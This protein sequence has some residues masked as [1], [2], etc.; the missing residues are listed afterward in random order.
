FNYF[1]F[2]YLP[3]YNKLRSVTFAL[4]IMLF[5]MPLLGLLGLEKLLREGW[6][7]VNQNK[8]IWVS[9]LTVGMCLLI[10]LTG[11][12]A[13]FL[14][15]GEE[16][17][18]AWF[19]SALQKDRMELLKSDAWR[20]F[21]FMLIFAA[22]LYAFLKKWIKEWIL[23]GSLIVLM[24]FDLPMVDRRFISQ[25]KFERKRNTTFE[26]W[27]SEKELSKDKTPFR[28]YSERGEG[29]HSY[30]FRATGGYSG[31]RLHR[32][33][34]LMDSCLGPELQAM[35]G[36]Y[37]STGRLFLP[38]HGVMSMM[39]VKYY[40]NGQKRTDFFT[41]DF[42]NGAAWF[43]KDVQSVNSANEELS[44]LQSINTLET[45]VV[46]VTKFKVAA[47]AYE[48]DSLAY[49]Q[50]LELKPPYIKYESQ[51]AYDGLAVFS[52]I[53]YPK[54]WH[55]KIDGK[56][57]PILRADYVLRALEVPAGKHSIEFSFEPKPYMIGNKITMA[58]SW[59]LVIIVA[60]SLGWSLGL[61]KK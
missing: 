38:Q 60:A 15:P 5:A 1:I 44:K 39:N 10:A 58:S 12:F 43:I 53:Y 61:E 47:T 55:A 17:F 35:V 4:V 57:V 56:E 29:N 3:G 28:I 2:D 31:A 36:Q 32:Y 18:P 24:L 37:N 54:G 23:L 13:D 51:S 16:R 11:G 46:D 8:L 50:Q 41:N 27:D 30:Y 40:I 26:M 25:D 21:W 34:E 33:E 20:S 22:A 9:V 49:I 52:E 42:A 19:R 59:L 7:K 48:K 14:K 45:A 6:S